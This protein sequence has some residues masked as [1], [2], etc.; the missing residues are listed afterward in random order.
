MRSPKRAKTRLCIL[1]AL[2]MKRCLRSSVLAIKRK[3][4]ARLA[5]KKIPVKR[6][7][8]EADPLA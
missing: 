2:Q 1:N 8:K 4:L 7:A 3:A 6:K 5:G